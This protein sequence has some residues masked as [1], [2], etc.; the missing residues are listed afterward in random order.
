[1]TANKWWIKDFKGLKQDFIRAPYWPLLVG[2][3]F[4]E[5]TIILKALKVVY[6]ICLEAGPL[7]SLRGSLKSGG[8]GSCVTCLTINPPLRQTF[9]NP[10]F[11]EILLPSMSYYFA[12]FYL[13]FA[14]RLYGLYHDI[15]LADI[16]KQVQSASP[17]SLH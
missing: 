4:L 9:K 8:R 14:D 5:I 15:G 10:N 17:T 1:M 2:D 6:R 16:F 7:F 13:Q 12:Y 11:V 3:L